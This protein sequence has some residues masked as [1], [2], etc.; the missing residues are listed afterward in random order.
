[1]VDDRVGTHILG[2]GFI[3]RNNTMAKNVSSNGFDILGQ[4]VGTALQKG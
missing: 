4:N 3:T 2:L 1:L